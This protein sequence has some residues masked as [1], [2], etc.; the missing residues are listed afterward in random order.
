MMAGRKTRPGIVAWLIACAVTGQVNGQLSPELE[1]KIKDAIAQYVPAPMPVRGEMPGLIV[2]LHPGNGG[3]RE[4]SALR[5][6]TLAWMTGAQLDHMVDRS[7]SQAVL[8][9]SEGLPLLCEKP[10][11][12]EELAHRCREADADVLIVIEYGDG[13]NAKPLSNLLADSLRSPT[14]GNVRLPGLAIAAAKIVCPSNSKTNSVHPVHVLN[15]A[16]IYAELKTFALAHRTEIEQARKARHAAGC[17]AKPR[18]FFES[19]ELQIRHKLAIAARA[20]WPH[21]DPPVKQPAWFAD[22]VKKTL[23]SDRT[24][25]YYDP[26]VTTEDKAVVI[27]GVTNMPALQPTLELAMRAV[28]IEEIRNQ[29]SL[30]PDERR[31]QGEL[32]GVCVSSTALTYAKPQEGSHRETQLLYGETV[33]LL[34]RQ[35]SFLLVQASDGYCGWVRAEAI[36]TLDRETFKIFVNGPHAVLNRSMDSQSTWIPR[37]SRLPILSRAGQ[38]LTL[39]QP[40]DEPLEVDVAAAEIVDLQA[41]L[42]RRVEVGLDMLYTPYVFAGRSPRGV[43]CSG[44]ITNVCEDEGIPIARDA[45][46]QFLSGKL[47]ATPWFRDNIQAGDRIY[48]I[49]V[50]GKIFH[51]GLA[52]SATHYLHSASPGVKINS[53]LKNDPLYDADLDQRFMAA[54]RP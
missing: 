27:R 34:D 10:T 45:A 51:T 4:A 39:R 3:S 48:F 22:L 42:E 33:F 2:L 19:R 23:L 38:R 54:K 20:L 7:G 37:G 15:A 40:T 35:G 41:Q 29:I 50:A 6:D 32:F 16:A 28:G 18:E 26:Q 49:D 44:F 47:V 24:A 25:V 14:A 46:Q 12:D 9:R 11:A 8:T 52:L 13:A 21:G 17:K 36:R 5:A 1:M 43:D 31:L 30:L 53:W